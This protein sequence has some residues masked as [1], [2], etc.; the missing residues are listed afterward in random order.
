MQSYFHNFVIYVFEKAIAHTV[1]T[2]HFAYKTF[3]SFIYIYIYICYRLLDK[4]YILQNLR[5]QSSQR[6]MNS[7]LHFIVIFL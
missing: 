5:K 2:K 1:K 7:I 3:N 4:L 6:L